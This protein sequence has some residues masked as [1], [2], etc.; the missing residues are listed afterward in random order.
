MTGIQLL[1]AYPENQVEIW[2]VTLFLSVKKFH[3][4]IVLSS[5]MKLGLG[6][7][8]TKHDQL[9]RLFCQFYQSC[10]INILVFKRPNVELDLR[11]RI[12][13]KMKKEKKGG[14]SVR[15]FL[16][17]LLFPQIYIK[18]TPFDDNDSSWA[19]LKILVAEVL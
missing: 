9:L 1:S 16:F 6:W 7:S 14:K 18:L 11:Q 17:W 15:V 3:A 10:V 4:N 12:T 2:L 19:N 13:A 8:H 5:S